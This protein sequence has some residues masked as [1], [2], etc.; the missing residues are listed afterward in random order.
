V[1]KVIQPYD[2]RIGLCIDVGHTWRT[3]TDP[4]EAIR[5]CRER[6]YDIHLKDSIAQAGAGDVPI[7]IGR[8]KLDIRGIL[9]ALIEIKYP[10]IVGLEYE[11]ESRNP[12]VGLAE[13]LGF[14]RG[15]LVAMAKE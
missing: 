1:W 4:V 9:S 3:G 2:K 8:G 5:K 14:V 13:S 6:L 15:M 12:V 10:H 7:E 11:K